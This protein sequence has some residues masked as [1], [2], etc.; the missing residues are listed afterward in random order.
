MIWSRFDGANTIVQAAGYD[1]AGPRL[2]SLRAPTAGTVKQPLSFSVAPLDVWSP[3][4]GTTWSF[5][6]GAAAEGV[7]VSHAYSRPGVYQ[8]GVTSRDAVGNS[9]TATAKVTIF[10]KA[11]A[12]RIVRFRGRR[13]Q[14]KLHCPSTTSCGGNVRLIA[15]VLLPGHRGR[16]RRRTI[17]AA[18]F[19]IAPK[20][21]TGV[22]LRLT[23]PGLAAALA[24]GRGGLKA[25]LSG[26]G[27]KHRLVV[28]LKS[29]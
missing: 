17:A 25:Q 21:V 2:A 15:A 11:S 10:A 5:G 29:K 20:A 7:A 8:V 22:P 28:L 1:A 27:V 19:A 16:H 9:T 3:L 18:P 24:T 4:G 26:G 6:D 23:K 12:K 14:L 13:A